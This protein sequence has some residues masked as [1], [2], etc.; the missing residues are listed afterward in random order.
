MYIKT[1]KIRAK[2]LKPGDLF[3]T[4]GKDYWDKASIGKEGQVGE[5]VFIRTDA[6]CPI[7][8]YDVE[9]FKIEIVPG[10]YEID[11]EEIL[12]MLEDCLTE[13]RIRNTLTS[14]EE[15]FIESINDQYKF[16]GYL[17]DKQIEALEKIWDKI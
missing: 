13:T 3:S 17:T 12:N 1:I 15:E 14:W 9:V 7:D 10:K 8:Q 5:K 2:D 16:K 11:N 4:Y 6:N